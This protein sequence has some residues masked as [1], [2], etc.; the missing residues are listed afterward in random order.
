MRPMV[1]QVAAEEP[2][3]AAKMAQPMTLTCSSR[4]GSRCTQGASP[5]NMSSDKRVRKR[6]SPIQMNIGS[7]VRS[8]EFDA[9]HIEVASTWP[10]GVATLVSTAAKPQTAS[11][12][13]IQTPEPSTANISSISARESEARSTRPLCRARWRPRRRGMSASR[14]AA[15]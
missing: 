11:A 7:A 4:P 9:A 5:A 14:Y 6:I 12:T 2:D 10:A 13:A 3:T 8:H 1:A 15:R